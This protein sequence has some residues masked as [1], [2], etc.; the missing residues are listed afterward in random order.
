[1]KKQKNI[2]KP[3]NKALRGRKIPVVFL[4]R[5]GTLIDSPNLNW[6]KEQFKISKGVAEQV[7]EINA[8][9]V[10]VI[11]VTNQPVVARG[12]ISEKDVVNL[13][14]ML[15]ERMMKKG[16]TIDKF[17]FCPHHPDANIE[18]YRIVCRCRK[19]KIGLF[20]Q[21]QKDF[22]IDFKKSFVVGDMT[23]DIFAGKK[24][25]AK[26]ILV[27]QGHGGRDSKFNVLPDI[28]VESTAEALIFIKKSLKQELLKR[29]K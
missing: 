5:D 25:N 2:T 20:L 17:Y 14:N 12:L 21:A 22:N 27:K 15:A 6:K 3:Q 23:Q 9:G 10:P 29:L 28:I 11:I 19:P 16:A 26:T 1:M 24:I 4:D 13:H 7:K 8:I 18:K